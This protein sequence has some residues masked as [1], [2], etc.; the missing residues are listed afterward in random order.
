MVQLL[1]NNILPILGKEL[2]PMDHLLFEIEPL[3]G[4]QFLVFKLKNWGLYELDWKQFG[5]AIREIVV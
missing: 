2:V 3:P 4:K 1:N 5:T